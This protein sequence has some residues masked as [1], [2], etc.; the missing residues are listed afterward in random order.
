M[1]PEQGLYSTVQPILNPELVELL[2]KQGVTSF[3]MDCIP[4]TSKAQ[5]FDTLSS[6]AN[7]S[8]YKAVLLAVNEFG[9]YMAGQITAA[10]RVPPAKVL[11]IGGGVAGLSAIQ[12]AK[13]LGAIVRVFDTRIA[14]KEQAESFGA[15]FLEVKGFESELGGGQGG[16][17]KEMSKEFIEAE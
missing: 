13:Q 17:A 10:G 12:T 16:Y 8:G 14:V 15:E 7:I 4:R 6:M 2:K 5:A 11:V 1:K 9:R 3:G